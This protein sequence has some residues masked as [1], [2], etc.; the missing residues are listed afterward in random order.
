MSYSIFDFLTLLGSLG[1]FL[2]GMKIMSEG[3]QKAA[4]DS[5]RNILSAMTRNRFMGVLTGFAITSIV[6]SSSATTVMVVSFVN[7]GLL[8]LKQS[9]GVIMGANI[10]TTIT[11]WIIA[12]L[13]FKVKMAAISIPIIGIAFPMLFFKKDKVNSWGE[14]LIGFA[15]VFIGLDFLKNS[16]PDLASSP[17]LFA[18]LQN[19]GTHGGW[20][21]LIFIGIGT[22]LTIVLQSSSAAMALTLVMC[23]NGWIDFK[24][25]AA[26]VL[27]E[28]IGT[29]IT[30]NLAA[31]IGNVHAKRSAL[32]H[33]V[34]NII[35]VLWM[36]FIFS[37]FISGIDR[38]LISSTGHS[39]FQDKESIPIAL[40]IF[41]TSF[42]VLNTLLLVGFVDR[43]KYLVEKLM[44]SHG[45]HDERFHLEYIGTGLLSTPELSVVEAKKELTKFG[46]LCKKMFGFTEELISE[47]DKKKFETLLKRIE[48]Y[49]DI[50]DKMEVEIASFLIKV[51][52]GL[53][54]EDTSGGIRGLLRAASNL[55]KIGDL[56]YH[57]SIAIQRNFED[58]SDFTDLQRK[59][60]TEMFKLLS[61][62]FEI[63]IE[64]LHQETEKIN[65][66]KAIELENQINKQRDTM[67]NLHF[68]NIER[69]DYNIKSG[70]YYNNLYSSC[71]KVGDHILNVSEAISGMNI[72]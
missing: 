72:E 68:T 42:N 50:T 70:L 7:A 49:E 25:G 2:Y 28:N 32:A 37:F 69:G 64:N 65:L 27:G 54:S 47:T 16:V 52:K 58:K 35:G 18:Q 51:S 46:E 60:I 23:F 29:T 24:S 45:E 1:M 40:S 20:S 22:V 36:F 61:Q 41:H 57:M 48:K 44:P 11:A 43:I 59:N 12:I 62:A 17:E 19:L 4:G 66:T 33:T 67:R 55:E 39:P 53:V 71:E 5:L 9:I 26:I 13:G 30:A 15:L 14:T 31:I 8:T 3:I 10:G 38:Y 34:F 56:S 6:Q 21:T 63:M